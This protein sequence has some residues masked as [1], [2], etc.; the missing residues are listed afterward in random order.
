[1]KD[2]AIGIFLVLMVALGIW[3]AS[4]LILST[5]EFLSTHLQ[6]VP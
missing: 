2:T 6:W 5:Y 1:M 3:K 4:D